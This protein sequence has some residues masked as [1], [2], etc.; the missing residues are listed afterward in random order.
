MNNMRKIA[1]FLGALTALAVAVAGSALAASNGQGAGTPSDPASAAKAALPILAQAP[2]SDD[3]MDAATRP[4]S[5]PGSATAKRLSLGSVPAKAW[6]STDGTLVCLTVETANGS[7][8]NCVPAAFA[9]DNGVQLTLGGRTDDDPVTVAGIAPAGTS[10]VTLTTEDGA[11]AD[12]PSRGGAFATVT[13]RATDAI[14]LSGATINKTLD[15]PSL[16]R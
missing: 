9:A 3:Q 6:L 4:E 15:L 2:T 1:L 5:V 12:L 11:S 13:A 8:S 14:T 16:H 7:G 10:R